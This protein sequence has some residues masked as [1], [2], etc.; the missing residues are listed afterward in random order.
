MET[1]RRSRPVLSKYEKTT[2][3]GTRME[4][5]QRGAE[6]FIK[7]DPSKPVDLREIALEE[8]QQKKLPFKISRTMPDGTVEVW[9]LDELHV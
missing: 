3:I 5:L 4:Q 9:S 2:I 8:L 6:P 7:V 1:N